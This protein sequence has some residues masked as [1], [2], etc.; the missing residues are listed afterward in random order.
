[1]K[2]YLLFLFFCL[3]VYLSAQATQF[4]VESFQLDLNDL[5][6]NRNPVF[7]ANDKK[8]ALIKVRTD[9][10]NITFSSNNGIVEQKMVL[11]EYWIYV[12]YDEKKLNVYKDGFLPLNFDIPVSLEESKVYTFYITTSKRFSIVIQTD[13]KDA[14]ISFDSIL[15]KEPNIGNINPGNHIVKIELDGF[16]PIIDT[17]YVDEANIF[18][19]YIMEKKD[20]VLVTITSEPPGSALIINN[21][22]KGLTPKQLFL[23]PN[24]YQLNLS[25]EFFQQQV[26]SLELM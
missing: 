2:I 8:C 7:D 20:L 9:L 24:K 10:S 25:K 15:L 1:M 23:Y 26:L 3:P 12:S 13:P 18:F 19:S 14:Q 22:Y 21:N 17:V 6:A 4:I 5:E 16:L 11:T